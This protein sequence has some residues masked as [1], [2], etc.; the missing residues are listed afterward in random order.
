MEPPASR[1]LVPSVPWPGPPP[2]PRPLLWPLSFRGARISKPTAM[3]DGRSH[4]WPKAKFFEGQGCHVEKWQSGLSTR[5]GAAGPAPTGRL[6]R[7]SR[8]RAPPPTLL[9]QTL[10]EGD[11]PSLS[12]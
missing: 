1:S 10:S 8:S 3:G 6:A 7:R 2:N 4:S 9:T 12:D 5:A 11:T